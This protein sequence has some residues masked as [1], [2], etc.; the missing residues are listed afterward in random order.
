MNKKLDAA[1]CKRYPKIFAHRS[2]DPTTTLMGWGFEHADG[3]YNIIDG[4][5]SIIQGHIDYSVKTNKE[6]I[7]HNLMLDDAAKGNWKRFNKKYKSFLP[8]D[9]WIISAK[10]KIIDQYET[11]K[12]IEHREVSPV[13]AQVVALQVKEKFGTLR[14]YCSGGDTFT[15]GVASMAEAMSARTCEECGNPGKISRSGW[16]RCLCNKHQR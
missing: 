13:C 14:F 16:L 8:T 3:W 2:G 11:H 6:A 1:L 4:M 12:T 15:D 10:Q 5:C 9:P 7:E